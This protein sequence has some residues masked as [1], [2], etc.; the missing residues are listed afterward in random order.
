MS[1]GSS[2]IDVY[3]KG[4]IFADV[5]SINRKACFQTFYSSH[6]I[7]SQV[8]QSAAVIVKYRRGSYIEHEKANGLVSPPKE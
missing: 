6:K 2:S 7:I 1:I 3:C 4:A 8:A 5:L